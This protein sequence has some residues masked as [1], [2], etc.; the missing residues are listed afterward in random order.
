M[1]TQHSTYNIY[2]TWQENYRDG[3]E[4]YEAL[5]KPDFGEPQYEFCGF[6]LHSPFGVGSGLL[7]NSRWI[8]LYSRLGFSLLTTK[9]VRTRSLRGQPFPQV[10]AVARWEDQLTCAIAVTD[11]ELLARN[12]ALVNSLGNPYVAPDEWIPDLQRARELIAPGQLLIVSITGTV[13]PGDTLNDFARDCAKCASLA[14][15]AGA[16]ALEVNLSCP[17]V[18]QPDE[19]IY[20][21]EEAS[22]R[23][24]GKV[25]DAAP[26]TPILVKVGRFRAHAEARAFV[27]A[28]YPFIHAIT[29]INSEPVTVVNA[30]GQPAFPGRTT[31]GLA[32]RPLKPLALDQVRILDEIRRDEHYGFKL[33]GLGGVTC[34]QDFADMRA[35]GADAVEAVTGA[36]VNPWLAAD[37]WRL[38]TRESRREMRD[39]RREISDVDN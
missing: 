23:V 9:T 33:I 11:M 25:R 17:N 36:M 7:W 22:A 20:H 24:L 18:A 28:V 39:E 14:L 3:P 26:D 32:G 6:K 19:N 31:A 29:A 8:E 27:A 1:N 21:N 5:P 15:Q 4:F 34:G 16:H 10:L 12:A 35:A 30:M 13:E 37:I 38:E 2:K